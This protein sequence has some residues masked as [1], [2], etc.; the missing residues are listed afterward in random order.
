MIFFIGSC[1]QTDIGVGTI[2]KWREDELKDVVLDRDEV[3]GSYKVIESNGEVVYC[4]D[5]MVLDPLHGE[6]EELGF[7]N[8]HEFRAFV[9]STLK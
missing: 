1:A 2:F 9:Q 3:L 5:M 4:T 6:L 8:D 7:D